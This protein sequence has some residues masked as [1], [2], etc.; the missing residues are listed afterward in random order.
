MGARATEAAGAKERSLELGG[1]W[2]RLAERL[3]AEWGGE[4]GVGREGTAE[5]TP[6]GHTG[7]QE[8]W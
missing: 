2:R 6:V 1:W 7:T 4:G 5:G 8:Q 3:L